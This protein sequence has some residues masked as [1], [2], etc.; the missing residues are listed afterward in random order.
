M[1]EME[2]E[3][4]FNSF[5]SEQ[6][7]LPWTQLVVMALAC[8]TDRSLSRSLDALH[9]LVKPCATQFNQCRSVARPF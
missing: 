2:D 7:F 5:A 9:D 4:Y 3:R 1:T 8:S 6:G